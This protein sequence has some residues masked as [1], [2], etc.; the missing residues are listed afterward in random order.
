[1]TE[2]K[3]VLWK[4]VPYVEGIEDDFQVQMNYGYKH[5]DLSRELS[6]FVDDDGSIEFGDTYV[7][8]ETFIDIV[9]AQDFWDSTEMEVYDE[10]F[11]K[12]DFDYKD[13]EKYEDCDFEWIW[14]DFK[15]LA[16]CLVIEEIEQMTDEEFEVWLK[17]HQRGVVEDRDKLDY[18]LEVCGFKILVTGLADSSMYSSWVVRE[19]NNLYERI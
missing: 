4:D 18:I 12:L 6:I 8:V 17:Y 11:E 10:A 1:M 15:K 16:L 9:D 14:D 7:D 2:I 19:L 5:T 13:D 3:K